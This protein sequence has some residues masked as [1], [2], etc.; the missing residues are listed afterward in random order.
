MLSP[1]NR[2]VRE[3]NMQRREFIGLIGA[4]ALGLRPGYAQTKADLPVVGLLSPL[5]PDTVAAKD[6]VTALRKACRRKVCSRGR[7]IPSPRGF[8][9]EILVACLSSRGN[10]V[11]SMRV[12][13]SR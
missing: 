1:E 7:T 11:R 12:S 10:W 2:F 13:S 4:T 5:K 3:L 6:R 9:K 8:R